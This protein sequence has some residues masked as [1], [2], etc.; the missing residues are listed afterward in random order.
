MQHKIGQP[1]I[2]I[3]LRRSARSRRFSL[4][5]GQAD[6]RV[7][8]SLP[9]R[10]REG[11]ALDFARAH[12][13]WIRAALAKRPATTP[14][15][16]GSQ[17]MV[18]GAALTIAAGAG[19]MVRIEGNQLI[20]PGDGARIPLRIAAF[21]KLLARDRLAEAT[22]HYAAQLGRS[23]AQIS[24]RDTRSR[25]GSCS[26]Q[27]ALMYNWRLIMAPPAVLRYVAA[28]EVAHL[29]EM[30]HSPAFWAVV[31]QLYPNWQVQRAWL[32]RHGAGLQAVPFA[33]PQDDH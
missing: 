9:L 14:L 29:V 33:A 5:V 6:G 7:L 23:V 32:K 25:W 11:E 10:A 15:S 30:N 31:A 27:G 20:V 13:G 16:L 4:R 26:P 21:L 24:L 12:E 18:E 17:I 22:D 8:L 1:P 28:H 2:D 19:R 3:T